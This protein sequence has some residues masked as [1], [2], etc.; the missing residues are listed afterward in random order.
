MK[1]NWEDEQPAGRDSAGAYAERQRLPQVGHL[2]GSGPVPRTSWPQIVHLRLGTPSGFAVRRIRR[3][4][5][6]NQAAMRAP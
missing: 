4:I 2:S 3:I 6:P 1:P 5:D